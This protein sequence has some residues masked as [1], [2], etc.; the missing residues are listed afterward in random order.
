[1]VA[2]LADSR[3]RYLRHD[4]PLGVAANRN[5]CLAH[6][7]GRYLAWLD[8]D[9]QRVPQS[10][11]AQLALLD[12]HPEVALVHSGRELIDADGRR[13]PD[14][15]AALAA[16]T[17]EPSPVAFQN[18]IAA[19]ELTTSTVV[20]RREA[21]ERCG[22]FT[23]AIGPSSTDWE[24]WLRIAL[25][26]AVAYTSAAAARYRQHDDT[27]STATTAAG[28]RLRC[29]VRVVQR[30][31]STHDDLIGDPERAAA[32]GYAGLAAQ[33]LAAA[34][35]AYTRGVR[36]QALA[37]T[38]L[39]QELV[40]TVDLDDLLDAYAAGDDGATM[41]AT[42]VALG[43]LA[44]IL[45]GTRYGERIARTAAGD[46]A[47]EAQLRRAG[48]AVQ[49]ITPPTSVIAAIAK[50][51]PTV[52]E[53]AARPGCNYPDRELMP[54]GYPVNGVAAVAHLEALA[55]RRGVT[56]LVIPE[57]CRWWL[58]EYPELGRRVGR[59]LFRDGDCAIY[60]LV[61]RT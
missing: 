39:A 3:V 18:L 38:S 22:P 6:A 37:A 57:A 12:E 53:H 19:N 4:Q 21:Q 26:G 15:P 49:A 29:N 48:L 44:T 41:R 42:R 16:D 51:D 27:I 25:Q 10:L 14:W 11:S 50:W 13:L 32:L 55:E 5:S 23:T 56:H 30:V 2:G 43:Q 7:R 33:A 47:W 54:S 45:Q 58:H 52:I 28:E 17:I 60:A 59:P 35:D 1:V 31:L 40:G 34:G 36:T 9:D 8:S 61:G 46:P 20:V 24:M